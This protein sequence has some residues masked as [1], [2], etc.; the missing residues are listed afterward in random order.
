MLAFSRREALD[1][2]IRAESPYLNRELSWLDFNARVLA[3]A[4]ER[5]TPL[6]ER[7]KFLSIFASNLDELYMVRVAALKR[8]EAAGLTS[9]SADGLLP[10]E[11][12]ALIAEK[13][14][15]L[16]ERH[17]RLFAGEVMN[18]LAR[19]G[20]RIRRWPELTEKQKREFDVLFHEKI[21]P[22]LTPLAVDPGHPFPYIS[23][24]SLNLA[25][26]VRDPAASRTHFA[27]VKVPPLLP[28]FLP[29]SEDACFVPLEDVIAANLEELFP[30]MKILEHHTFRVTRDAE[31]EVDDDGAED[32]LRALE[33]ELTRRRF[34]RAVRLEVEDSMPQQMLRLLMRELQVDAADVFALP[35]PLDLSSLIELQ[36][37]DRPDLKD[38][39]FQPVTSR[40]FLSVDDTPVDL[41]AVLRKKDVLV[42]HPYETFTAS[43]QRFVEQAA[44]DPDVLAIKQTLYRTSGLSPIVDAL[45]EAAESG[46]QVVVLVEI[47]ARFDEIANI[48]WARTLERAGCHVVYGLVGLKTHSK[49]CMVVRR[50][51]DRLRRYVHIGRNGRGTQPRLPRSAWD[52]RRRVRRYGSRNRR[53]RCRMSLGLARTPSCCGRR[54]WK[55]RRDGITMGRSTWRLGGSLSGKGN[56]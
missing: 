35:E 17:A 54:C 10:G 48:N 2:Y 13:A 38:V 55:K 9:P 27:R 44:A 43:V 12:I 34:S 47:K 1:G 15:P 25:V 41:F 6:L 24:R 53:K 14:R 19:A 22:I 3:L 40:D 20:I 45:I 36:N 50:E 16:T 18:E 39:P 5:R 33:A 11:Q 42:H 56:R 32:L 23:K 31:L 21:F 37:I 4:K 46:K 52:A 30:G 7:V 51:G 28:R 29:F 26:S 49:L 8:Q